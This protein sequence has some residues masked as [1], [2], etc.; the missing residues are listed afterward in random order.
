MAGNPEF[1]T[2]DN[3]LHPFTFSVCSIEALREFLFS[4]TLYGY[5]CLLDGTP[6][7]LQGYATGQ[8]S[9]FLQGHVVKGIQSVQ[10]R[11]LSM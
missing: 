4:L 5:D 10:S 3:Y 7:R 2:R 1:L 6:S 11:F 9:Y 8:W